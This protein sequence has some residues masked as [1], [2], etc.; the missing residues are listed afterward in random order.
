[1]NDKKIWLTGLDLA[2][3][4]VEAGRSRAKIYVVWAQLYLGPTTPY[5]SHC[6][7]Y[8][9]CW[10]VE[11]WLRI[12]QGIRLVNPDTFKHLSIERVLEVSDNFELERRGVSLSLRVVDVEVF[13]KR[14][15]QVSL[16]NA[17]LVFLPS[18][19]GT[20]PW[21]SMIGGRY[22]YAC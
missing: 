11:F 18:L 5:F 10:L 22:K 3:G 8:G 6:S 13:G 14:I 4:Q 9:S 19:S 2:S 12:H 15:G 1:M 16:V 7:D 21:L 20:E 17:A